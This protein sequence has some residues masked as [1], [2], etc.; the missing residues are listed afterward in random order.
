MRRS[1]FCIPTSIAMTLACVWGLLAAAVPASA[2]SIA[3]GSFVAPGVTFQD[4]VESSV[5]DPVPLFGAPE[6]FAVGLDFDPIGFAATGSAGTVDLT[7]GQL[8]I[9]LSATGAGG[10]TS[11]SL[12]EAGDFSLAGGA[13]AGAEAIA[14][15]V[16]RVVVTQINGVDVAPIALAPVNASV[17]FDL[18]ANPG[19]VQP[20]SP[21]L[22]LNIAAQLGA[23]ERATEL[24]IVIDD[25]LLALSEAS[26]MAFIAKK[27]FR[28]DVTAVPEPAVAIMLGAGVAAVAARRLTSR[29][30]PS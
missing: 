17:S 28:I 27:D 7:D 25:Q 24:E 18:A 16:L 29:G 23:G 5:T 20:W 13:G 26:S 8:N 11:I 3:Y 9:T 12:F 21:G 19:A 30:A 10:I 1:R 14:G 4:V 6:V 15:A 22:A 2:A